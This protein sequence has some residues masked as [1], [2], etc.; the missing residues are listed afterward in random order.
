MM[1]MSRTAVYFG[2]ALL[3][4]VAATACKSDGGKATPDAPGALFPP[5]PECMGESIVALHGSSPQ[6]ISKLTIGTKDDG[7]DLDG[8]GLPDNKLGGVAGIASGP[9]ADAFKNDE[10]VIPIEF[11]DAPA[12]AP[13]DCIKF[14]IY[15]SKFSDKDADGAVVTKAGGDCNDNSAA[16]HPGATEDHF[17]LTHANGLRHWFQNKKICL[18]FIIS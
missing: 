3:G 5:V 10:V 6:V 12:A 11:F 4:A 1:R 7:F 15:L 13:D 18:L 14:A 2:F 16:V 8:D 9:I 17:L